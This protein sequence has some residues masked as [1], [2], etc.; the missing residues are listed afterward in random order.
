MPLRNRSMVPST[1]SRVVI[2]VERSA[3]SSMAG[4]LY[5]PYLDK[6]ETFSDVLELTN[7]L[8]DMMDTIC[9]PVPSTAYRSFKMKHR[10]GRQPQP[11][12][13]A[14]TPEAEEALKDALHRQDADVFMVH[15]QFRQNA[16]WQGTIKWA[17]QDEEVRFRS[18]LEL[19]KIMDG[20]LSEREDRQPPEPQ[21]PIAD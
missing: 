14:H 2:R 13:Q 7:K 11:P 4:L 5:N 6:I 16:T 10:P 1:A 20:A 9:F 17:D 8:D 15:V 12:A 21:P 18:T 19:L 3:P